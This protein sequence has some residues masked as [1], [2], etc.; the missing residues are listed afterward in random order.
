[1]VSATQPAETLT[2]SCPIL[3]G[4]LHLR[5]TQLAPDLRKVFPE[6][7]CSECVALT[8]IDAYVPSLP[9]P[10]PGRDEDDAG[11]SRAANR[12]LLA[13]GTGAAPGVESKAGAWCRQREISTN[14]WRG[15][16][17]HRRIAS[18][19]KDDTRVVVPSQRPGSD[20]VDA[21]FSPSKIC[22]EGAP[23]PPATGAANLPSP[24]RK[25]VGQWV[26]HLAL[27]RRSMLAKRT[28]CCVVLLEDRMGAG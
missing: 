15:V 20:R 12:H 19:S 13:G 17:R 24:D 25:V 9:N 10:A 16:H 18:M 3:F 27:R 21:H 5:A 26:W 1:M 22:L 14:H 8:A 4:C 7:Q 28:P 6:R 11:V 23:R 2:E